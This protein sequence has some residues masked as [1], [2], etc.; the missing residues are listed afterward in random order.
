MGRLYLQQLQENHSYSNVLALLDVHDPVEVREEAGADRSAAA[1]TSRFA[2]HSA[3]P[4][5]FADNPAEDDGDK[6]IVPFDSARMGRGA[7]HE[8]G[9]SA[10]EAFQRRRGKPNLARAVIPRT[11]GALPITLL[12]SVFSVSHL[13]E[14]ASVQDADLTANYLAIA[15]AAA[16]L[17]YV[18]HMQNAVFHRD[19][20]KVE[21][22]SARGLMV[23]AIGR[24]ANTW[25]L[26]YQ[27]HFLLFLCTR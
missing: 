14:I 27:F 26:H 1:Q 2:S 4:P 22:E 18:E 23:R 24:N 9:D 25:R 10:S 17:R 12:S 19:S 15:S 5:P 6:C 20:L 21:L 16:L 8:G 11:I 13:D 7:G 3:F